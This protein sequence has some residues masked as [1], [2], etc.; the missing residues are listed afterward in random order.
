M[1]L[2]RVVAVAAAVFGFASAALAGT[3]GGPPPT[4][5]LV[6]G[7]DVPGSNVNLSP[8]LSANGDGTYRASGSHEIAGAY[9]ILFDFTLDPDPAISGSFTLTSLSS[10]TQTFS[11][12]ATLGGVSLGGPSR[13]GGAFGEVTYR[14]LNDGTVGIGA[15]PFYSARID[16]SEIQPLGSFSFNPISGGNGISLTQGAESFGDPIP[17]QVGPGVANNI[18]VAFAF[19]LT[20]MDR[21]ELQHFEFV[22]VPESSQFG[23]FSICLALILCRFA[24]ER[25]SS[26]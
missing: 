16:G 26:R 5:S 18:Q 4:F 22:V 23:L 9:S 14:D 20:G 1:K 13:V 2:R 19:E 25:A 12:S 7:S 3:V 24:R 21:V 6:L 11:V 8:T 10:S 17:S 15:S